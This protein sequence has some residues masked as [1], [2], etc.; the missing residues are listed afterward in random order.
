MERFSR[1]Y[2]LAIAVALVPLCVL[3]VFYLQYSPLGFAIPLHDQRYLGSDLWLCRYYPSTGRG[4]KTFIIFERENGH[5][6]KAF[7]PIAENVIGLGYEGG[8][9]LF[10]EE[11]DSGEMWVHLSEESGVVTRTTEGLAEL[12]RRMNRKLTQIEVTEVGQW[13]PFWSLYAVALA[14]MIFVGGMAKVVSTIRLRKQDISG[15]NGEPERV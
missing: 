12:S 1:L 14:W 8:S 4:E 9:Y 15:L 5:Y 2:L 6:R 13:L 10:R 11:S 3:G 7:V